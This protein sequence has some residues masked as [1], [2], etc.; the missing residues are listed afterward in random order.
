[1]PAPSGPNRKMVNAPQ[2]V[3]VSGA[4]EEKFLEDLNRKLAAGWDL[5]SVYSI[6]GVHYGA[7]V[8]KQRVNRPD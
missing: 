2:V 6:N 7:V 5:V 3:L 8:K 1:M 4:F